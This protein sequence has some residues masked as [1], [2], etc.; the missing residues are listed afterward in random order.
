MKKIVFDTST[1]ISLVTNDLLWVLKPLREK[2]NGEFLIPPSVKKELVDYPLKINR[3][4]FEAVRIQSF[5]ENGVLNLKE[6]VDITNLLN[7]VN[8]IYSANNENIKILHYGEIEALALAVSNKADAY[9][10]DERTMR[11]LIEDPEALRQ[12]LESKLHTPVTMDISL[13]RNF[14]NFI[15]DVK[16]IRST[17]LVMVAYELGLLKEL[18]TNKYGAKELVDGVLWGLR[19]KGCAISTEE[20]NDLV[21]METKL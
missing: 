19:L 15:K 4:K 8:H 11:W 1:L 9:I 13:I 18:V 14:K 20:I 3:F 7:S 6:R 10:V 21:R 5:I 2:F 17:E 16:V 12:L